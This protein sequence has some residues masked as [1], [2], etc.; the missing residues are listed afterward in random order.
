MK[1][2]YAR[3]STIE[4][5]AGLDAQIRDLEAYGCTEIFQEQVSSVQ[6]RD[7]LERVLKFV[8][9]G[10]TLVVSKLDRL[11]RSVPDLIKIIQRLDEREAS[12]TILDMNLATNTPTGKLL[13]HLVSSISQFEREIMLERQK[14]GISAA[15]AAGKYRGRRPTARAKSQQ[16]LELYGQGLGA[17]A[18]ASQLG[19][20]RASTYRIIGEMS[21]GEAK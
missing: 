15:K 9:K 17:S 11:A 7:E 13:L 4:Q 10:D 6:R 2:G 18:I 14:I 20:S 12:L 8:R 16:V 5:T 1:I 21:S 19:I 3:V